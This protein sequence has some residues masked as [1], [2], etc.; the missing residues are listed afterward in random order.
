MKKYQFNSVSAIS[1][2][3]L[4]LDLPFVL[5]VTEGGLGFLSSMRY[6]LSSF[7]VKKIF[8]SICSKRQNS[9]NSIASAEIAIPNLKV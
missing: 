8:I 2:Y 4:A 6:I 5:V 7:M 3:I 1:G 9:T